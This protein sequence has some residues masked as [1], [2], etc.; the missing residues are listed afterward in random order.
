MPNGQAD[1][2]LTVGGG[3]IVPGGTFSADRGKIFRFDPFMGEEACNYDF[4]KSDIEG[5]SVSGSLDLV[6]AG[7]EGV[8]APFVFRPVPGH[9]NYEYSSPMITLKRGLRIGTPG[10]SLFANRTFYIGR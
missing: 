6:I 8:I 1:W 9:P 10:A 7:G 4:T 2:Y 3:L 5:F